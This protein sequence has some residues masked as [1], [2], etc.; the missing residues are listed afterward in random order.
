MDLFQKA[1]RILNFD[2]LKNKIFQGSR[3]K[4][5]VNIFFNQHIDNKG[6][7]HDFLRI[8]KD[9]QNNKS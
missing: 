7:T 9:H 4:N 3:E 5:S 1:F 2:F 6:P 8:S